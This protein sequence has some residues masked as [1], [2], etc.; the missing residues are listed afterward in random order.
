MTWFYA[1]FAILA[2]ILG[3]A[4]ATIHG[5]QIIEEICDSVD[6]VERN[7]RALERKRA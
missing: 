2:F 7:R 5:N 3:Y 1:L 4:L 6:Q